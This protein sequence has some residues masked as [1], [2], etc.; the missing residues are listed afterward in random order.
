MRI[1]QAYEYLSGEAASV[2]QGASM[3]QSAVARSMGADE[4]EALTQKAADAAE[5]LKALAHEGRLLILCHLASGEKSV[6]ELE[7]FLSSRQ[8]A[9][10]QQL[11]R[12]RY[13]GLVASRRDGKTIYYSLAD[14]RSRRVVGL[15]YEL[16]CAEVAQN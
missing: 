14:G 2:G 6:T 7:Q 9:V 3:T 12:L 10:S 13:E 4:I 5:F 1:I 11:A 16:F 15:M 8:P